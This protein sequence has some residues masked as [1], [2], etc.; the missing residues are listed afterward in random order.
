MWNNQQQHPSYI[1][2]LHILQKLA[3]ILQIFELPLPLPQTH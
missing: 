3:Q 2:T 1:K